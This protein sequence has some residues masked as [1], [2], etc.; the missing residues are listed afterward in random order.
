[1][2]LNRLGFKSNVDE[3]MKKAIDNGFTKNGEMFDS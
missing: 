3:L 2:G 1:M